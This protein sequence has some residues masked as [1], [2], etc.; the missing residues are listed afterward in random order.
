MIDLP[1]GQTGAEFTWLLRSGNTPTANTGPDTDRSGT[2]KILENL[3]FS[4]AVYVQLGSWNWYCR[5]YVWMSVCLDVKQC[6]TR[7]MAP[8]VSE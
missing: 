6:G 4:P 5:L 2:G 3:V 8:S 1:V 7:K